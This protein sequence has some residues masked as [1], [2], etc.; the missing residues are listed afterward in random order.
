MIQ[1]L[2]ATIVIP[3]PYVYWLLQLILPWVADTGGWSGSDEIRTDPDFHP[4]PEMHY[5]PWLKYFWC[6]FFSCI[7]TFL[8][9]PEIKAANTENLGGR[10]RR[11]KEDKQKMPDLPDFTD[12]IWTDIHKSM[13][14]KVHPPLFGGI[15]LFWNEWICKF[16]LQTFKNLPVMLLVAD[17]FWV[18][19]FWK[20]RLTLQAK[21]W[22]SS[23][24]NLTSES[25]TLQKCLL[26][27]VMHLF[28][29]TN[30]ATKGCSHSQHS[31]AWG[32]ARS[33][34][35]RY[36]CSSCSYICFRSNL[37]SAG[38]NKN[39]RTTQSLKVSMGILG[40]FLA[41]YHRT[42]CAVVF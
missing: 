18:R 36:V 4:R 40:T 29:E 39:E 27:A 37:A 30:I 13:Q 42:A 22:A 41:C 11:G 19:C 12:F 25:N 20:S 1:P 14:S 34:F 23:C 28:L 5:Y 2:S 31:P 21:K 9:G 32:Y 38:S 7:S 17:E 16:Y 15:K 24:S 33:T 10:G 3:L 6:F 26:S 35:P 8:S